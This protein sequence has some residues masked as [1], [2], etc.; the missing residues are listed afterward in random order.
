MV[1]ALRGWQVE[2]EHTLRV[3]PTHTR[4]TA[5]SYETSAYIGTHMERRE[6]S[7]IVNHPP[8]QIHKIRG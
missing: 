2:T 4:S 7:S 1:D 5:V 6:F 3:L 8:P